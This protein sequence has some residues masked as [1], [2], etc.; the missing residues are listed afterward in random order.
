MMDVINWVRNN[1][2]FDK[3]YFYGESKPIH[4]SYN[5]GINKNEIYELKE[6]NKKL[7]PRKISS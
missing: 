2:E 3:I 1:L 6:K 7:I 5:K 4:I